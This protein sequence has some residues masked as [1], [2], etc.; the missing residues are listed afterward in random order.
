[1]P[2]LKPI[3]VFLVVLFVAACF[4]AVALWIGISPS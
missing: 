4:A 3:D 1:M 2:P